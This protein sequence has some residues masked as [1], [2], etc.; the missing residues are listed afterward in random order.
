VTFS[1]RFIE[2]K[3]DKRDKLSMPPACPKCNSPDTSSAAKSPSRNSYWR[4]L[5]CGQVW[6]PSLLVGTPQRPWGR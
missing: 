3:S 1:N 2:L 5:R 6:N 4:C